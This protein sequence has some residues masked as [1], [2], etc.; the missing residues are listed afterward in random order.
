MPNYNNSCI[1]KIFC[2]DKE[3]KDIYI[4]STT[5][6]T[7]RKGGHKYTCNNPNDKNYNI[8]VYQ[9]IRDNGGWGNWNMIILEEVSCNSRIELHKI[10]RE[11]I[12]KYNS[13]LNIAIPTRTNT[14]YKK[15]WNQNNKDKLAEKDKAY[16]EVNKDK[17]L[18]KHKKYREDNKDKIAEQSKKY[19]EANK[20]KLKEKITCDCGSEV[21]KSTIQRHKRT[22]KH[23]QNINQ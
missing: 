17:I 13:S 15:K 23:L 20:E 14:E 9:F 7:D 11:F 10:E 19:R 22:K 18:E 2:K 3:I 4:G 6:F 21:V 1:Y 12:E 8:K 16:Y 5:N